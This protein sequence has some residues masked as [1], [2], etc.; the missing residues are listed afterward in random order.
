MNKTQQKRFDS[1]CPQGI[2]RYVRLYDNGGL[3]EQ[4]GSADRF[5]AVFSGNY[6][7]KTGGMHWVVGMSEHPYHP[8]GVGMSSEYRKMVDCLHGNWPPAIGRKCHLG[9]RIRFQDLPKDCQHLVL[10]NYADLWDLPK[11]GMKIYLEAAKP[12]FY[13]LG[14]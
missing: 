1:L 9:T 6:T 13:I 2:P 4:G 14:E 7:R 12:S 11:D 8:Q 10:Q 3:D 5:C